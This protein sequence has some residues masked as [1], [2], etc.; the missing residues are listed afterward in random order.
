LTQI[1]RK[2]VSPASGESGRSD[3]ERADKFSSA[4]AWQATLGES[5]VCNGGNRKHWLGRRW[6]IAS[7]AD[8]VLRQE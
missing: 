8:A 5:A 6:S 7:I 2:I 1:I 3:G 4:L